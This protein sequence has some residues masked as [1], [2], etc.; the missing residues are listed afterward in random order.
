MLTVKFGP[1]ALYFTFSTPVGILVIK[2]SKL[3][4]LMFW[5]LLAADYC[6]NYDIL[7]VFEPITPKQIPNFDLSYF[8]AS[9]LACDKAS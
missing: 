3:N 4:L 5:K 9:N 8:Y 1:F 7:V 6:T 2:C